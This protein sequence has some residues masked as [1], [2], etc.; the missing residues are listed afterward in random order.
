M[1]LES[2]VIVVRMRYTTKRVQ[3]SEG[4]VRRI[5]AC[6]VSLERVHEHLTIEYLV[7]SLSARF[8]FTSWDKVRLV[9]VWLLAWW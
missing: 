5:L 2:F 8:A 6:L 7:S 1:L 3:G 9:V 4:E